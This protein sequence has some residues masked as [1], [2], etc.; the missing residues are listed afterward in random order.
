MNDQKKTCGDSG[1]LN[2]GG[3]PRSSGQVIGG[4]PRSS[5]QSVWFGHHHRSRTA[6]PVIGIG[7]VLRLSRSS[8]PAE[9]GDL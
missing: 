8:G 1:L 6:S 2:N 5:G 3:W 4:W 9:V 7:S